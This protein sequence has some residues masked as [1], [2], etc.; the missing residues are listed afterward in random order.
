MNKIYKEDSIQSITPREFTRLHPGTYAGSVEYSTQLLREAFANALDE[1]NIGHGNLIKINIDTKTNVISIQDEGQGFPVN[2]KRNDGETIVSASFS[3]LNTSGKYTDD[4]YGGSALGL[5]GIGLK[6]IC[7]LSDESNIFTSDGS[8]KSEQVWFKDG[9]FDKR[10]IKT[11]DKNIRGTKITWHPDKQF[12]H[13]ET[14]NYKEIEELFTGISA[15]C[16]NLYIEFNIDDKQAIYHTENGLIDLINDKVGNNEI[17]NKRFISKRAQGDD[18]FDICLTYTDKYT[19]DL[20]AY[21]NYGLTDAGIH[22][23]TLRAQ[24]T[25]LI[26]KVARDKKLL[27]EK[28]DNL[29]GQ[30]LSE[31]LIIVFNLK[32]K[33]VEYDSQSKTK[34]V[35]IDKTLLNLTMGEDFLNWL[36]TNDKDLKTIVER[37]LSARKARDAARKARDAARKPKEKGLKAKMQLS[38]KF[39]D[40]VSKNPSERNLL[41]VEGLSAGGSALEARNVK[42]DCIYMLR[43]KIISPLKQTIDK[44]L[45]NQEMHDIIQ[46]IGAGFGNDKFDITKMNFDK[47][48]I[49]TDQDSDGLDIELLLITFFYTYMRPLVEAGKLYRAVTPL[50]IITTKKDKYYCYTEQ[51][52]EEWKKTHNEKY[53]LVHCK[54]LGEVSAATLKEICFENQRFKRITVSDATETIKLLEVLQG[55]SVTPRKQFIYDNAKQ[56]GFNFM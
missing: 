45:A 13:N 48:V 36:E 15:L 42:T 22:I 38:D 47:I 24:I 2:V 39:I 30:E 23:T 3:V 31:G 8:G 14:I 49:T 1:H 54:G 35:D 46:V 40:C 25:R 4:V 27:K 43:G 52:L 20:T 17:L 10:E 51:E 18:V 7:Y 33:G 12:F 41:L 28:E 34:V 11:C 21:V 6:L 37:A 29:T 55:Q 26:N 19:E 50:Y 56:L 32:A 9:I 44:I 5:N 16:P 53:D